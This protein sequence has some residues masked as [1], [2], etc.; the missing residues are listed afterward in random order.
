MRKRKLL[1]KTAVLVSFFLLM[2]HLSAVPAALRGDTDGDG[3]I[4]ILDLIAIKSVLSGESQKNEASDIDG[5][6]KCSGTDGIILADYLTGKISRFPDVSQQSE[7]KTVILDVSDDI[8]VRGDGKTDDVNIINVA[9]FNAAMR[10]NVYLK[11]KTGN[12]ILND[13]R[14]A[15]IELKL[16]STANGNCEIKV[17][18]AG[19]SWTENNPPEYVSS[20]DETGIYDIQITSHPSDA[21]KI[22]SFDVTDAVRANPDAE[23]YNFVLFCDHENNSDALSNLALFYSRENQDSSSAAPRLVV[24]CGGEKPV[25][26]DSLPADNTSVRFELSSKSGTFIR[27]SDGELTTGRN[28]SPLS[29]ACFTE[30]DGFAGNSTVSFESESEPGMYICRDSG[31]RVILRKNDGTEDF[32]NKASFV[33]TTGL[34]SGTSYEAYGDPGRWLSCSGSQI[35]MSAAESEQAQKSAS[36]RMISRKNV[37]LEDEFEGD[38]L[39]TSVWKYSYPWADHHN[40][41]A[42]VRDSQISVENGKLVLTATRV[43]DDNW[44]KDDKGETGYTDNIGEKKWRKYSHLTG[45]VHLP[46]SKYPLSGSLY[47]EGKF[48]MPDR[49]GFWPAFWLNGNNSWPPEIDIFEYLSNTPEKIYVGIHRQDSSRE[50]GDGGSGWWINRTAQFFQKEFHTYALDWGETY[51]NYYIDDVLVKSVEDMAVI[52]N[53]KNMY[54]IINL[55]VGGWAEE[56][57]DS[58]G[59]NTTFECDY[60]HIYSY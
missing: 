56:P 45:V 31:S 6:G 8:T 27:V 12:E 33:K 39:D 55:G 35:M 38:R 29:S 14:S 10:R 24:Q 30:K 46:F 20:P 47:M 52:Q 21:G 59:D 42:V 60:V 1:K 23:E 49:S 13:V 36:F 25:Q 18:G 17:A 15:R 11:F 22:I 44:I 2:Q 54:L 53:Q 50:N 28:V 16:S 51:I 4:S 37:I 26:A 19:S 41:S 57:S 34:Y 58:V 9:G 7:K 32:I 40:Y 3:K 43:A 48:R 5:D